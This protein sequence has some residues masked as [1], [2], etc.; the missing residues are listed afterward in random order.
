MKII[1]AGGQIMFYYDQK[2]LYLRF[3]YTIQISS[4]ARL[5]AP[6]PARDNSENSQKVTLLF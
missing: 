4:L 5:S 3:L 1:I 6:R 2:I